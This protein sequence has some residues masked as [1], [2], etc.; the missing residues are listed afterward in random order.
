MAFRFWLVRCNG[1]GAL[2]HLVVIHPVISSDVNDCEGK[3]IPI[4]R[5]AFIFKT[6][7]MPPKAS[8]Y[9]RCMICTIWKHHKKYLIALSASEITLPASLWSCEWCNNISAM[10]S[11]QHGVSSLKTP[12][13]CKVCC[14]ECSLGHTDVCSDVNRRGCYTVMSSALCEEHGLPCKPMTP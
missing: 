10:T 4:N 11:V 5:N 14:T 7:K 9:W 12:T 13:Q 2:L 8:C 3:K 1:N 6:D